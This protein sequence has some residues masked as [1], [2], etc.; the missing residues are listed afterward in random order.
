MEIMEKIQANFVLEMLGR[1]KENV[2]SAMSGLVTQLSKD[3]G[4]K[5]INKTLHDAVPAEKTPDLFTTFCELLIEFDT[6]E[7]LLQSVF[8]YLPANIE[9]IKPEKV[10]ISNH[11]FNFLTNRLAQKLHQY[12]AILKNTLMQRDILAKKL[13]EVAPHLFKKVDNPA[14]EN[15]GIAIQESKKEEKSKKKKKKN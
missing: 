1:P 7:D 14:L 5:L 13:K 2:E 9:V 15:K 6:S 12:D 3:K 4:L 10:S 8:K 11:D